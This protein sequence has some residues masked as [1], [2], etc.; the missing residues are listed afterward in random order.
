MLSTYKIIQ[1]VITCCLMITMAATAVKA[2]TTL[3]TWWFG[4]SGAA[5]FNF[6]D[7]T[8]QRLNN[9]LIAP[10]AF[11]KGNGVRP[12]ASILAEYRPAGIWG[13]MLNVAY[14][15]RG[16]KFN[17]VV[18]PCNCPATLETSTSYI[19]VEPSIR[20]SV[21][22]TGLY[23]FAGPRVA[24]N[25][26]KDFA[27]TQFKQ[28]NTD[29]ELSAMHK[30]LVSGQVGVGYDIIVSPAANTT[31][32]SISPFVSYHPYF[33]QE[34]RNIESWSVTT[35]RAGI[36]LKFGKGHKVATIPP[37]AAIIPVVVH[38]FI[39]SVQG[40]GN[41]LVKHEVSET[42]PLLDVVFFDD[43]S[44]EIP[45]RYVILTK[46][47]ATGF[48]EGQL[49]HEQLE[50]MTDRSAGQLNVYHNVLNILGDRMR[51]N[52]ETTISLDGASGKGPKDAKAFAESIKQYLV[53][54]F[55]ISSSR[56]TTRGSFKAHPSSEQPGGTK[57]LVL[58]RAE[59]RRVD[60]ESASPELLAEVGGVMMKPAQI[61]STQVNPLDNQVVF[62]VDS[63]KELL[64]SWAID[65]TDSKGITQH[66]GPF[67]GDQQNV[68][69][70]SILGDNPGGDYKVVMTA[71]TN[72]G[73]VIKKESTIHL[74]HQ[75][76]EVQ[77]G[78]RY[79]IVFDFDKAKSMAEYDKFLTG[80]VSPLIVDGATVSIHGHTDI[81]GEKEHN[82]K[83]SDNRAKETQKIIEH[84]IANSGRDHVK[85][86]T[87][88]FGADPAHS[89]F[90]NN[91]PEDRFYN[92]TVI[93]DIIPNK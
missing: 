5:N 51:A 30:T 27:Y 16:G 71:E 74:A 82:Q 32:I 66:Y 80:I 49:Q 60:I 46:E 26:N 75:D 41:V 76:D 47:Q 62:K 13:A 19:A 79:S 36:A 10:T 89:P 52:P 92:R 33:G 68:P 84:A 39:F 61:T 93:I 78:F 48:R 24:F 35:V 20:L 14:D 23:F 4:V 50:S 57:E 11:H 25:I 55:G 15:G 45:T 34:P 87:S 1:K 42:L 81:I 64:K 40:P 22:S 38:D 85:F 67:S 83:L 29:A 2:Q 65:V 58:L 3:P 44:T 77:K 7:G 72:S 31:M 28:P 6:Y 9:S 8:T 21:P 63:A 53:D 86:E 70:A 69:Q 88:G 59:D 73:S 56:I 43:G 91:L 90:E 12:Y 18:A 54:V 17:D 37:P